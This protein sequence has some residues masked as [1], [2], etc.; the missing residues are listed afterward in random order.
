MA[1]VA[2]LAVVV[3]ALLAAV[4]LVI[5]DVFQQRLQILAF[6]GNW[7]QSETMLCLWNI[8]NKYLEN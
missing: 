3:V 6:D 8:Q 4:C 5:V 2:V 7:C 1:L